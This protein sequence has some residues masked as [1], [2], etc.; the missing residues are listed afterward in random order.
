MTT[1]SGTAGSSWRGSTAGRPG[2]GHSGRSRAR[3]N[4][5]YGDM[6]TDSE[7]GSTYIVSRKYWLSILSSIAIVCC[8]DGRLTQSV[9]GQKLGGMTGQSPV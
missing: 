2:T 6:A 8:P 3:H 5:K 1:T 7:R 9:H 4:K